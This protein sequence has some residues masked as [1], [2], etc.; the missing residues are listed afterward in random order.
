MSDVYY[1]N[2]CEIKYKQEKC[3]S[4]CGKLFNNKHGY[5]EYQL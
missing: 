2:L 1:C 3:C 4:T 5:I